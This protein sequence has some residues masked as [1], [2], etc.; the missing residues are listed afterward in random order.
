MKQSQATN[1]VTVQGHASFYH[2]TLSDGRSSDAE[3]KSADVL[4]TAVAITQSVRKIV[5]ICR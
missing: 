1:E 3:T 5:K 2:Y 4:Q